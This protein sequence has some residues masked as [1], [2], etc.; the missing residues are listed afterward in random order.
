MTTE[1]QPYAVGMKDV[2]VRIYA[3]SRRQED[4][5]GLTERVRRILT[6]KKA[7][8]AYLQMEGDIAGAKSV[9]GL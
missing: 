2:G 3:K 5:D 1:W 4:G 9:E 7:K 6:F 8:T